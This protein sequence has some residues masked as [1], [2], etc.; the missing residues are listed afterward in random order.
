MLKGIASFCLLLLLLPFGTFGQSNFSLGTLSIAELEK[1]GHFSA[2][3]AQ[4][5]VIQTID[6][7]YARAEWTILPPS[8]FISGKIT[9]YFKSKA[10]S[11]DS[12]FLDLN[13]QLLISNIEQEGQALSYIHNDNKIRI[14]LLHPNLGET[15]SLSIQYS[16][17]PLSS[18]FG[19]FHVT[20][21][22]GGAQY[23]WTLSEPYGASDWW[24]VRSELGDKLDSLDAIIL[25]SSDNQA[26]GNGKLLSITNSADGHYYHWQERHP[27][28]MYLVGIAV[29]PYITL[30]DTIPL[31]TANTPLIN[32]IYPEKLTDWQN[33]A[34]Y[35]K[36]MLQ[37]FDS[38]IIPYPFSDEKYGHVQFGW[39]GGMEHQ[40]MSS[41]SDPGEMLLA[42]EL[43]HQWFGDHVTCGSW[44]D[45]W[46]NEGFATYFTG[47]YIERFYPSSFQQWKTDHQENI[48]QVNDGSVFVEDTSSISRIF[49]GRLSYAKG[50][51]VLHMLR[52]KMGD[53][54]FFQGLR[55]YLT[56]AEHAAGFARTADLK[57][58][59]E[60]ASGIDL[61]DYFNAWIYQEGYA[62][63]RVEFNTLPDDILH[64]HLKQE[65]SFS[66]S[67]TFPLRIPVKVKWGEIDSLLF[68]N[69]DTSELDY[70]IQLKHTATSSP[71]LTIDSDRDLLARYTLEEV[72]SENAPVNV[73]LFPNP[74]INTISLHT[75]LYNGI[76]KDIQL[77]SLSGQK[78][79]LLAPTIENNGVIS[80]NPATQISNG[81]YF[82]RLSQQEHIFTFRL[83][84]QQQ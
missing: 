78:I 58:F 27:I 68:L 10:G 12:L 75:N 25:T 24:P 36:N 38:L 41:V 28:A 40:T 47:V 49:D 65:G 17:T 35:Q 13:N 56:S 9:Y 18:G 76:P 70:W 8:A 80:L 63:V 1:N 66:T 21:S 64:L 52:K 23:V 62:N 54:A 37:Y 31:R 69:L 57:H 55:N 74:A 82:L 77:Y 72:P 19:S 59:C 61:N 33:A 5:H 4:T 39:G 73:Q 15:D 67:T 46:L 26:S 11:T 81:I 45:I 71:Q 7:T 84:F 79:A 60:S 2:K 30:S 44:S 22:P 42:H 43:A 3:L 20:A 34:G 6:F 83:L 29:G 32:F 51:M 14:R 16:G 53:V 48:F 50:A